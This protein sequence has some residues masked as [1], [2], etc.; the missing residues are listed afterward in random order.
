MNRTLTVE[1][2]VKNLAGI[3]DF[4]ESWAVE[5][6][7][8]REAIDQLILAVDES[9]TNIM[10]H[11]YNGNPGLIE[12]ACSVE[13]S[14]M[15]VRLRDQAPLFDPTQAPPPD[16]GLPLSLR[17]VGGLGVYLARKFVDGYSYRVTAEGHNEL[18]LRKQLRPG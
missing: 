11:G 4:V 1:A 6:E 2:V 12:I 3:R 18:T 10:Q 14:Q 13:E 5:V 16:L 15:V 8:E 7:A 9:T 17:A